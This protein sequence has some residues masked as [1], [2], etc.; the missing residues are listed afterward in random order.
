MKTQV[1]ILLMYIALSMTVG[2][3]FAGND[4]VLIL[5]F[6]LDSI[7]ICDTNFSCEDVAKT[8]LPQATKSPVPVQNFDKKHGM[9]MFQYQGKDMWVHQSEVQLNEVAVASVVCTGQ[10]VAKNRN[11]DISSRSDNMNF[12]SLG[13]GEDCK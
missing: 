10:G 5:D 2:K 8:D 1:K 6:L 11:Q 7:E 12:S 9:V 3:V 4:Q 13:L